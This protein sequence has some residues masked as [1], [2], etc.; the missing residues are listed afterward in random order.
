[1]NDVSEL[2]AVIKELLTVEESDNFVNGKHACKVRG[3]LRVCLKDL[4]EQHTVL[5]SSS[6]VYGAIRETPGRVSWKSVA[7]LLVEKYQVPNDELAQIEEQCKTP[8]SSIK[9]GRTSDGSY[10]NLRQQEFDFFTP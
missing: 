2:L 5:A 3:E 4:L 6:P 1:M 9:Y 7:S 10:A 8:G